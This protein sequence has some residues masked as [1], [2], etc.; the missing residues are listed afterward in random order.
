MSGKGLA[1]TT[2]HLNLIISASGSYLFL[3]CIDFR[4]EA[5]IGKG[6]ITG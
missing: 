3:K 4:V 6:N 2:N 5:F 1:C